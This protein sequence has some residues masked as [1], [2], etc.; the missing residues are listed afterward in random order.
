VDAKSQVMRSTPNK[1]TGPNAGGLRQCPIPT[2]LAA[3]VV[4][5]W[6]SALRT[7]V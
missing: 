3:G 6:R 5:F 7:G 2:P 1:I 4:Q